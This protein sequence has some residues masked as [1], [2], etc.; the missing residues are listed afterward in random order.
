MAFEFKGLSEFGLEG[1]AELLNQGF[2][3][4]F[5]KISFTVVRLIQM[6]SIDSLDPT[7][8]RVVLN[9][10]VPAGIALIARRGQKCRLAGMAVLPGAR[11]KGIGRA[12]VE[13]LLVDARMRGETKMVLEVIQQNRPAIRLYEGMGFRK[14]Q[15][16][17]GYEGGA[18][19]SLVQEQPLEEVSLNAIADAVL[20]DG[21]PD[22]P[23]QLSGETLEMLT[24][25]CRAFRLDD[26]WVAV[27]NL[28]ISPVTIRGLVTRG[29]Q[30]RLAMLLGA[31]M[32]QYPGKQWRMPAL[33]PE[34]FSACF[35]QAG[36]AQ[37]PISQWQM[38]MVL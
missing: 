18:I 11:M 21:L 16:L 23:W 4:Y 28:E 20:C 27:A 32:A 29:E 33:W 19:G 9:D 10:G 2:S 6:C 22:L 25:P 8:S 37:S 36:F 35:V 31:L 1:A 38:E 15:R 17:L 13:R 24:P 14:V 34:A 26:T 30:G 3:D 7:A 12:L 5:L